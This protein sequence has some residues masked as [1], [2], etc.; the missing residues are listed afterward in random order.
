[1]NFSKD[2]KARASKSP[3]MLYAI[4][5]G[6]FIYYGQVS[7]D[8][9]MGFFKVRSVAELNPKDVV[10]NPVMSRFGIHQP[11]IGQA[12]RE[13]H[14]KKLGKY[15]LHQDLKVTRPIVQWPSLELNVSVWLDGKVIK[16]TSAFDPEIQEYEVIMAYDA[17]DHVPRR[18]AV[19]FEES[20]NDL[21][22]GGPVWRH[23]KLKEHFAKKFPDMEH[24]EL[25]EE[26][27]Y[28]DR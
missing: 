10:Q 21:E 5:D 26:W 1:M 18:L 19:D 7:I 23:R 12:L 20:S 8:G 25:P 14:W 27:V 22:Y 6:N 13:G 15:E 11:T 16:N 28:S 17:I 24:H 3:G 2:P 4:T 9:S